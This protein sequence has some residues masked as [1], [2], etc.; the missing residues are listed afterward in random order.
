A[1]DVKTAQTISGTASNAEGS[2]VRVTLGGQTYS[3]TVSSNGNWSLSVPAA[4]LAA[5]TDGLQT[6]TAS[7]TNGAGSIGNTS[8]SL[9]VV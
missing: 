7:V 2:V 9:G 6:V 3:T 1:V 8:A 5:I 4:N